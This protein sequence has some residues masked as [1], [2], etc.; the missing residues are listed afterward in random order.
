M[1]KKVLSERVI[2]LLVVL[3]AGTLLIIAPR[4]TVINNN[5]IGGNPALKYEHIEPSASDLSSSGPRK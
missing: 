2:H 1:K 5:S 3:A 4:V